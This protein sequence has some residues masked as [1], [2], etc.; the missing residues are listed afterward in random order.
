[1]RKIVLLSMVLSLFFLGCHKDG[2]YNPKEKIKRIYT[3][4][5]GETKNLWQEWTW[6]KMLLT[7]I[8]CFSENISDGHRLFIYEKKRLV[9]IETSWGDYINIKYDGRNFD[10]IEGFYSDGQTS[11]TMKFTHDKNKISK[12]EVINYLYN[13]DESKSK[14][15]IVS[16]IEPLF[17]TE[18]KQSMNKIKSN[19][20]NKGINT[21][22]STTSFIYDGENIKE[23]RI[24]ECRSDYYCCDIYTY[25]KYDKKS[26]PKYHFIYGNSEDNYNGMGVTSKN[27]PLE[28]KNIW[29]ENTTDEYKGIYTGSRTITYD[30]KYN[31]KFPVE[32]NQIV[33][34]DDGENYQYTTFY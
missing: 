19:M 11:F 9:K 20:K 21:R 29:Q 22:K 2:V 12:I 30:Y 4:Y 23:M 13:N 8:E 10:K 25:I 14:R 1:M 15:D 3:Q 34:W 7:K 6:N 31:G 16:I 28:V 32:V 18:F 24:E 27:N 17:P 26:N 5:P 33:R